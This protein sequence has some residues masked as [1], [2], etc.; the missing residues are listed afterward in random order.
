MPAALCRAAGGDI[1][2]ETFISSPGSGVAVM[3]FACY[4]GRSGGDM[5][6]VE[7]RWTR[8]DT[9]DIAYRRV[10]RDHGRTWSQPVQLKTGEPGTAGTLRRHPHPG[11]VDRNGRLIEFWTEGVLPTDDPLEG[12]RQWNIYYRISRD[13]GRTFGAHSQVVHAGSEFNARH[14]LPGIWTGKNCV[15]LGDRTCVPVESAD[16]AL[17]LP[18]QI[19]P[20]DADGKLYNPRGA[21]TYTE[22]AVLHGR[23]RGNQLIWT[24]SDLV[25]ADPAQSTRGMDEPTIAYL[26]NG[27]LLMVLRG[28]NDRQHDLP[29]YRWASFSNDDGLRW[30]QPQ[31]WTY[32]DGQAFFSPSACS[33]LVRHSSGRLYWFGNITP[34]NPRGNRPRY[35]FV[36]SEVDRRTGLLLR[37]SVRIVDTLQ[38]G[39][40]PI[41]S[42]SN[43][44]ARED[45][46]TRELIVHMTRLFAKPADWSGDAFLY[47]IPV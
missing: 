31:P 47:R 39:E 33:Q 9:I 35:P 43:F 28:S 18:V 37:S 20:L 45:R 30:T 6:S 19:T 27:R 2:R 41:L 23:W 24:M 26:E 4:A 40:D 22:A 17:M 5:I 42:L 7:Q 13:G 11:F 29:S 16:G 3:A 46:R 25:R 12:L 1:R 34:E 44:Y 32:E 10:S 14:P 8:S 21:Y 36:V 38:T 15:M